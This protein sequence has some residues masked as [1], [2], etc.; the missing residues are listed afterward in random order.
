MDLLDEFDV[1]GQ[2]QA[3]E[4]YGNCKV[5][6]A[7][8]KNLLLTPLDFTGKHSYL[9]HRP[10]KHFHHSAD[11]SYL[12]QDSGKLMLHALILIRR[13]TTTGEVIK[14]IALVRFGLSRMPRL[15]R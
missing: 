12:N 14:R 2:Q 15:P 3:E 7:D 1:V 13:P 8:C 6:I 4:V 9:L 5:F 11:L 10:A